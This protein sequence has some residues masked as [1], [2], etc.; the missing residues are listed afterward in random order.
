[1]GTSHI[2]GLRQY[3]AESNLRRQLGYAGFGRCQAEGRLRTSG[4][5]EDGVTAGET[6]RVAAGAE[7][8]TIAGV[9]VRDVS[10]SSK[11][12]SE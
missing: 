3:R 6:A 9:Q 5:R 8:P 11:E 7:A 1:M 2:P 12:L 10:E 4:K